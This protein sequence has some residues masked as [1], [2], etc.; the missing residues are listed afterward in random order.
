M[1]LQDSDTESLPAPFA[2]FTSEY[3]SQTSPDV[4]RRAFWR[5]I[6]EPGAKQAVAK[7]ISLPYE[8]LLAFAFTSVHF[9]ITREDWWL[10]TRFLTPMAVC[11]HWRDLIVG[12]QPIWCTI[13][14][15]K[16]MSWTWLCLVRS[17]A[18]PVN[19]LAQARNLH[20]LNRVLV[21]SCPPYP[22]PHLQRTLV[23]V[24]WI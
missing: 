16:N 7:E 12:T 2:K 13:I 18:I 9:E 14:L 17:G 11:P 5:R 6:A 19:L 22:E 4:L 3:W 10:G 24:G 15:R 1:K 23:S 20:R 8:L 21:V